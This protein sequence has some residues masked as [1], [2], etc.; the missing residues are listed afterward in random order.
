MIPSESSTPGCS[1]PPGHKRNSFMATGIVH[2][3]RSQ[4]VDGAPRR[5]AAAALYLACDEAIFTTDEDPKPL[6][7]GV[8][9]GGTK[10]ECLRHRT[11]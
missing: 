1:R 7:C 5:N 6:M 4:W 2:D 8:E 11:R 9:L 10:C 3:S